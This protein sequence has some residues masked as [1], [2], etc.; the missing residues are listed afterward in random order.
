M[1]QT[2][3]T[4]ESK[5][6]VFKK[7]KRRETYSEDSENRLLYLILFLN[8]DVANLKY[9][10]IIK[11]EKLYCFQFGLSHSQAELGAS[12]LPQPPGVHVY[13]AIA[14]LH[15]KLTASSG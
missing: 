11:K 9:F 6:F 14:C 12:L 10:I 13:T 2:L 4:C 7:K 8:Q 1:T 15:T 5:Y 3:C